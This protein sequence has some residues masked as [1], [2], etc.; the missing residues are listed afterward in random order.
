VKILFLSEQAGVHE[1]RFLNKLASTGHEIWFLSAYQSTMEDLP[2]SVQVI[3]ALFQEKRPGVRQVMGGVGRLKA[4]TREISPDV[5]HA[6]PVTTCAFWAALA[7]TAPLLAM[8]WNYDLLRNDIPLWD[9]WKNRYTLRRARAAVGDS[10]HVR[11]KILELAPGLQG[12]IFVFPWGVELNRFHPAAS[13]FGCRAAQ[14]WQDKTLVLSTRSL[15]PM[16]GTPTLMEAGILALQEAPDLRFVFAA[17]GPLRQWCEE[18]TRQAGVEKSFCFL[19]EVPQ[20][21]MPG[22]F[23]ESDLYVSAAETDGTSIS[24]LQALACGRPAVVSDLPGNREWVR[25]G[26]NGWLV[27]PGKPAEWARAFVEFCRLP[28]PQRAEIQQANLVL[29]RQKADWDQNFQMLLAAYDFIQMN[30]G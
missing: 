8:S 23:V 26:R 2:L 12:R 9:T 7:G 27:P 16:Y 22:L 28:L 29:A 6:G 1:K 10:E 30:R 25:P 18:R 14:G 19:G 13:L 5:L 21:R 24:L 20:D 15:H 4:I 3:P 17:G 11:N